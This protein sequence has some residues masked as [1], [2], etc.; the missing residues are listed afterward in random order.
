MIGAAALERF[1]W[2]FFTF[3]AFLLW[4]AW[5]LAT[6]HGSEGEPT[7]NKILTW[8]ERVLPTTTGYHGRLHRGGG[9]QAGLHP[10]RRWSWSRSS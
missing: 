8:V 5:K 10:A 6:S 3:G 1:S 7:E 2:L 4:T 9:R